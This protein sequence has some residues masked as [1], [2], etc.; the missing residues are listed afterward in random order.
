MM[1]TL[2]PAVM[3]LASAVQPVPQVDLQRYAGTWYEI[4]RLP[5]RFQKSCAGDVAANYTLNSDKTIKVVNTCRDAGTGKVKTAEGLGR[6]AKEDKGANSIL[7]VRFAPA[8]LSFL[9][10]LWGDYRIIGLD[11]ANYSYALVGSKDLQYLWILSRT[12]ILDDAVYNKLTA[13][14][15]RQGYDIK[16]LVRTPQK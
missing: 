16:Q 13:E 14:A 11:A 12:K 8:F 10:A 3:M 7:E 1:L 5:N 6:V 4:A 9:S 15:A 2:L